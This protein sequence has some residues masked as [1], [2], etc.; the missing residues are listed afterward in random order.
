MLGDDGKVYVC[1]KNDF[2]LFGGTNRGPIY[3]L[4]RPTAVATLERIVGIAAFVHGGAALRDDG[5][6]W[7]W[8][9]DSEGLL[10]I[11]TL[12]KSGKSG[13]PQ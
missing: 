8:G 5:T 11:G 6:V 7:M 1:G 3:E 10:A 4:P 2:G 9:E 13:L 12:S